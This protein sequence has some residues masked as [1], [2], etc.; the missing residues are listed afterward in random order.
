MKIRNIAIGISLGIL[1]AFSQPVVVLVLGLFLV[2]L[3]LMNTYIKTESKK[4]LMVIFITGFILRIILSFLNYHIA[5]AAG[6]GTD[7]QPDGRVYN[8]FAF[9]IASIIDNNRYD[10]EADKDV[11]LKRDIELIKSKYN[12]RLPPFGD[13]QNGIYTYMIGWLYAW[14][15][16]APIAAKMI[17]AI[18]GCVT[19]ILVYFIA[20][21]LVRSEM[22]AK[23]SAAIMMF[24]P[25][26]LYWSVTLLRDPIANCL[27]LLYVLML[28]SYLR[29]INAVSVVGSFLFAVLRMSPIPV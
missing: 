6:M 13:Y 26:T 23:I 22:V 29:K 14:L 4:F 28:L 27:F 18:I 1:L 10:Q 11:T 20:I 16:Y 5:E 9:Y 15:G 25:S 12:D 8:S 17:N 3:W 24:L 7:T 21:F 2:A 19:A